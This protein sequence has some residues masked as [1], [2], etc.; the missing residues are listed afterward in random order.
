M[1][2]FC[3]AIWFKNF[4]TSLREM[5][6]TLT[7]KSFLKSSLNCSKNALQAELNFNF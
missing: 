3:P 6:K 4:A 1:M 7:V 2:K 5:I